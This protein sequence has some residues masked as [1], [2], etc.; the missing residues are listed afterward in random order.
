MWAHYSHFQR[1]I[2]GCELAAAPTMTLNCAA[3]LAL[4]LRAAN[5]KKLDWYVMTT[6][7]S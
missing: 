6:N 4:I 3:W 1:I 7:M 5:Q 2:L